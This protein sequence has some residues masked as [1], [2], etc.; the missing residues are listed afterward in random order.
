MIDLHIHTANSSGTDSVEEILKKAESLGLSAISITDNE[1]VKSYFDM[2]KIDT[3]KLYS[4]KIITGTEIKTVFDGVVIDVLAYDFDYDQLK[5]S[6]IVDSKRIRIAQYDYLKNFI[7]VGKKL[8]LKFNENLEVRTYASHAFYDE[9]IKYKENFDILPEL[10]E[11]REN[12]FKLTQRNRKSPFFI[13][14]TKD[15]FNISNII[16]EIHKCGGKVFLAHLYQYSVDNNKYIE[17]AKNLIKITKIDGIECYHPSFTKEQ[18]QALLALVKENDKL[19]CGGSGYHGKLR[20]GVSIGT[21]R[22]NLNV[23]DDILDWVK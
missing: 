10:K 21:G 22:G 11:K 16:S 8:G 19:A 7:K 13:N 9:V 14:E 23:P 3:K 18:I 5:N 4:G 20:E 12:F 17:F 15:M 6:P 1:S 2:Q